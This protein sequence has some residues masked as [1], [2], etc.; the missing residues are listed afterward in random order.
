MILKEKIV[1]VL[2]NCFDPEIPI[3]LWNLGLIY[4]IK[5]LYKFY[6]SFFDGYDIYLSKCSSCHG[7]AR[8]GYRD[9]EKIG[10]KFI[11]SLANIDKT[12]RFK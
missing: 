6:S 7:V 2:K 5:L 11:P 12:F 10:D 1:G 4:D 8:Q 9:S 3:D